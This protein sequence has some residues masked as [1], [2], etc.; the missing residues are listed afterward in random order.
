[1]MKQKNNEE[2]FFTIWVLGLCLMVAFVGGLSYDLWHSF[3]DKRQLSNIVD[4]AA[5]AG[6]SEIDI[7]AFKEDS[8]VVRLNQAAAS[9]TALAYLQRAM[10]DTGTEITDATVTFDN[11]AV[12]V[13]A[14]TKTE[15]TLSRLLFVAFG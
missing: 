5:V 14:S 6:A 8:S 13:T 1:M 3:S 11:N 12:V 9:S 7:N 4:A 15:L 10:N 2:G